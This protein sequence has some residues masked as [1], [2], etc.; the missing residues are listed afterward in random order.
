M[1]IHLV[2]PMAGAGAR[3]RQGGYSIPK[4]LIELDGKPFF[5]HSAQSVLRCFEPA[6]ISFVVLKDHVEEF[7]IDRR[8]LEYFPKAR[9]VVLDHVLKGA[10]L[11]CL[12]GVR[13]NGPDAAYDAPAEGIDPDTAL[14]FNDCDH[15]FESRELK[16]FASGDWR[17]QGEDG[18][19]SLPAESMDG[20]LLSFESELPKFS[21][22]RTDERGLAAE[23]REKVVI[24]SSAICGAYFFKNSAVFEKYAAKYLENCSYS[25]YFMS[26]VYNEMIKDG[27][28]V[29]VLKTDSHT[30]FGTPEELR[31]L[32]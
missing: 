17:L 32:L 24:S 18:S 31:Q 16:S 13:G 25:E 22:V 26:G 23:T 5:W 10:V 9:I 15:S 8:I 19:G 3:F 29:A 2:M 27:C 12:A 30:S 11:S 4:P 14:L 20:A 7:G 6:G 21:Y 28:R 1:K